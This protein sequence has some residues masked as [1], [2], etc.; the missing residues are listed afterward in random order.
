MGAIQHADSKSLYVRLGHAS[1]RRHHGSFRAECS[2]ENPS[3]VEK[4]MATEP[5]RLVIIG[6]GHNGLVAA[7]YLAKAGFP[8]LVPEQREVAGGTP[9]SQE[10][11]PALRSP[12]VMHAVS[13]PLTPSARKTQPGKPALDVTKL[14]TL[15]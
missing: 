5:K 3:R 15:T 11:H 1:R 6:A 14:D 12:T 13:P 2:K 10:I 8:T 4:L 7:F 9:V